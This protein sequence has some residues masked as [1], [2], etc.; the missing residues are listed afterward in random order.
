M[1]IF[2]NGQEINL[3]SEVVKMFNQVMFPQFPEP[4]EVPQAS[5]PIQQQ[6]VRRVVECKDVAVRNVV[7]EMNKRLMD[8]EKLV[9]KPKV[10]MEVM[11]DKVKKKP[12]IKPIF[13]KSKPKIKLSKSYK[14]DSKVKS[15]SRQKVKDSK[16]SLK[17][18]EKKGSKRVSAK[19]KK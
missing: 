14:K 7:I 13:I 17:K 3:P 11:K 12:T 10:T 2:T 8:L 5:R 9:K 1:K 19:S 16:L 18:N 15:S 6:V 4:R